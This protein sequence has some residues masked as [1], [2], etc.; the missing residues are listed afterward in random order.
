[1]AVIDGIII[2]GRHIIRSEVLKAQALDQLH[3][4]HRG[5]EKTK[6][7]VCESI[8]W[9]NINDDIGNIMKNCT[10]HLTFQQSQP[11]DK[12]IHHYMPVRSW[13]VIGADMFT[14]NNKH[15]LCIVD[16]HSK[17]RRQNI[18]QQAA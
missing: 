6:L 18:Y 9:I 11:K 10:I 12:M 1:M 17:F 13:D 5:I 16:Y 3:I 15:Y 4:N 2:K 14:L 7:L 8:Y